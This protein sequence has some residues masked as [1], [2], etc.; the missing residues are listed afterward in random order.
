M[1]LKDKFI[2][3]FK[4]KGYKGLLYGSKN[5]LEQIWL[6]TDYPIW[7]AHYAKSTSYNGNYHYWQ[8]CSNGRVDG[9]N[10]DVDIDIR[11]KNKN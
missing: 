1:N 7:L 8:I 6:D 10:A 2:N 4:S 9:I 11:Y 3:Y 5:Y